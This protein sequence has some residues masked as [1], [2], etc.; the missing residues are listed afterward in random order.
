MNKKEICTLLELGIIYAKHVIEDFND[1]DKSITCTD[2]HKQ[3][4]HKIENYI[5][6]CKQIINDND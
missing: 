2:E 3:T 6:K 4:I 5:Q 1:F